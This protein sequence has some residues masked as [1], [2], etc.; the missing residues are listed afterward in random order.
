M[1]ASAYAAKRSKLA[2]ELGL[3]NLRAKAAK[4]ESAVKAAP[5]KKR[6]R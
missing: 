6:S 3:G 2:K 5:G 4:V 1:V